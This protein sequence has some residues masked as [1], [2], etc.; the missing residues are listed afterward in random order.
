[1]PENVE[2]RVPERP[3]H[4][5]RHDIGL[6]LEVAVHRPDHHVEP[7]QQL[8]GLIERPVRED[9]DLD[10]GE[11]P[12]LHPQ[13]FEPRVDLRNDVELLGQPLR[14]QP[15]RNGEPRRVIRE[16]EVL[17]PD[18]RRGQGHLV[19]RR[20]AVGPVGVRV[21]VPFERGQQRR[22]GFVEVLPGG[23][24]EPAQ[25]HGLLPGQRLDHASR[26]DVA[27]ARQFRQRP[28]PRSRLELALWQLGQLGR[29]P[30]ERS[31]A[32]GRFMGPLEQERDA[33]QIGQRI[34]R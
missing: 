29:G 17:V 12:K 15:T 23:G 3:H 2:V 20:P 19:D 5:P 13:P 31:D 16:H 28:G 33:T 11:D 22:G 21:A 4:P 14:R 7:L 9:V 26:R 6:V 1:M 18:L 10:P 8:V 25:V 24:F 32:I 30:S 34:T 27:Y